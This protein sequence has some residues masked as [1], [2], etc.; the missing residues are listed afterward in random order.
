VETGEVVGF[1]LRLDLDKVALEMEYW[2]P[3]LA[4]EGAGVLM[5]W[6]SLGKKGIPAPAPAPAPADADAE[7]GEVPWT[8]MWGS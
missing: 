7:V 5:T 8:C 4:L 6:P 2:F 1:S 3:K